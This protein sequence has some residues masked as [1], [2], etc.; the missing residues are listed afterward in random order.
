M[1]EKQ[2]RLASN[3]AAAG[4]TSSR[5]GAVSIENSTTAT[6]TRSIALTEIYVRGRAVGTVRGTV[7]QKTV[8][9]SKHFLRKPPAICFDAD[10][11][12]EAERA[13]AE[14]LKIKDGD[15]GEIYRAPLSKLYEK[16]FRVDRGFGV[17][18]AL[19]LAEWAKG[20]EPAGAQLSMFAEAAPCTR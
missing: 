20:D 7:L 5:A 15:T 3:K 6:R 10:T 4:E 16:G 19:G 11:L 1:E 12:K 14:S 8:H 18:W 9:S 17:Q 13:G 2:N